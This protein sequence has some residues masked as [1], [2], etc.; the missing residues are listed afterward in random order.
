MPPDRESPRLGPFAW[1]AA[2]L[3]GWSGICLLWSPDPV[4]TKQGA[5]YLLFYLLPLGLIAV[6]LARRPG[7]STG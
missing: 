4:G 5:I 3:V 2:V 6:V 1:P 7:G